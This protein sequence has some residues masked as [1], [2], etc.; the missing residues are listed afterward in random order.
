MGVAVR[1]HVGRNHQRF[2]NVLNFIFAYIM[3][4][5]FLVFLLL[6][7]WYQLRVVEGLTPLWEN[8]EK[9]DYSGNDIGNF[10]S[11][12]LN[13]CKKKCVSDT[14]CKGIVTDFS[15]D[16]PGSCWT[17]NLF[18]ASTESTNRFAYKLSRR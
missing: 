18:G 16:G 1:N 7:L 6:V 10:K 5:I 15:G 11:V 9:M 17:K 12:S 14:S 13:E 3:I 8:Q 4:A 2:T